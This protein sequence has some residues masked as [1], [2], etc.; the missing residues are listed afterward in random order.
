MSIKAGKLTPSAILRRLGTYSRKNRL[1]FAMREL[2]R[3]VR[4]GFLL[5]YLSDQD[6]RR[7]IL[8]A[9]NKSEAFNGFLKWLF[10]GGE[11]VITDNRREEQ[12]KIIIGFPHRFSMIFLHR[13]CR[14][15]QGL[16]SR[17]AEA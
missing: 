17:T 8:R 7:T 10:F 16:R 9:M 12:R 13:S 3:V 14:R 6:L 5:Q 2:G 4:T 15:S 1:Y 11:G